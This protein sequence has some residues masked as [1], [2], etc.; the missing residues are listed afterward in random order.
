LQLLYLSLFL[1]FPAFFILLNSMATIEEARSRKLL[2]SAAAAFRVVKAPVE[3]S[4]IVIPELGP[5]ADPERILEAMK[6]FLLAT[7]GAQKVKIQASS[8]VL[9]VTMQA[10]ELFLGGEVTLRRNRLPLF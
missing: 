8:G 7:I 1:L 10:N 2:S 5:A 3:D 6:Q 4:R 9:Q